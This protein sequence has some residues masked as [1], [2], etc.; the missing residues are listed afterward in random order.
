PTPAVGGTPRAEALRYIR[1]H[2]GLDRGWYA[3]PVGWM[4]ASGQGEVAVALRSA[5]VEGAEASLVAGCGIVG[6]SDPEREYAESS[7]KLRPML[8]ALG[9]EGAETE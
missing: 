2:E 9:I 5:L 6:D 8:A 7:V 4:A 3:A 1:E